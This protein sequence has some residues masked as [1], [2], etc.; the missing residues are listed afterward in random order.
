[1]KSKKK[2][3]ESKEQNSE[4]LERKENFSSNFSSLS[5]PIQKQL[6]EINLK[7]QKQKELD[8]KFQTS[9]LNEIEIIDKE[10]VQIANDIS[11]FESKMRDFYAIERKSKAQLKSFQNE[12]A[13]ISAKVTE[14]HISE[15]ELSEQNEQLK[16]FVQKKHLHQLLQNQIQ[17]E[18]SRLISAQSS[19]RQ[20]ILSLENLQK[21]K[22]INI[23]NSSLLRQKL[24]QMNI[25][26]NEIEFERNSK[27]KFIESNR[28]LQF[29]FDQTLGLISEKQESIDR[30]KLQIIEEKKKFQN[31]LS[32]LIDS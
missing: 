25:K 3:E 7:I 26:L 31:T 11:D 17:L 9:I 15:E 20:R 13:I 22:Q 18:E 12:H 14:L 2:I 6:D 28:S 8:Q 29:V 24:I 5:E 19:H 23:S 27:N 16:S 21:E 1:M 10:K 4:L 32:N 30:L